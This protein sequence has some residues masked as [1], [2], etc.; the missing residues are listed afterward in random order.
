MSNGVSD[1]L[2]K[3]NDVMI[4]YELVIVSPSGEQE[5][6]PKGKGYHVP[7]VGEYL[8]VKEADGHSFFHVVQVLVKMEDD[9]SPVANFVEQNAVVVVEPVENEFGQSPT[10]TKMIER[11]KGQGHTIKKWIQIGY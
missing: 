10:H 4:E 8:S 3:G 5:F 7:R 2:E 11:L 9:D 6:N 1:Q